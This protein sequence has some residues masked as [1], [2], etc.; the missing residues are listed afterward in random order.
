[1]RAN[2]VSLCNAKVKTSKYSTLAPMYKGLKKDYRSTN[3]VEYKFWFC[4]NDIKRCVNGNK[5][6]YVLD[7]L[8]VSNTWLVK[9]D[10]NLSRHEVLVLEVAR[11]QMQ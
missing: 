6:E 8:V 11:F 5:M 7:W 10:T 3:N 1:M 9:I 4:P 2:T